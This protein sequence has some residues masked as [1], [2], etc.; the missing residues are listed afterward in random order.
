[1]LSA[2]SN[3]DKIAWCRNRS[4][5]SV[6]TEDRGYA[7]T[8]KLRQNYPNPFNPE[9]IIS[10]QLPKTAEVELEIYNLLGK[11][12]LTLVDK[13]QSAGDYS[14]KWRGKDDSGRRGLYLSVENQ[15]FC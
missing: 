7:K 6:A 2:S 8:F 1:M 12:V 14:V 9:T 11:C 13:R 3:D 5:A 10:Y 4:I 15:G